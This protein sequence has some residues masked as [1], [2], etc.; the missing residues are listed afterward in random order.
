M[1]TLLI[2]HSTTERDHDFWEGK[3]V[4]KL[5][6]KLGEVH[7]FTG[8][9]YLAIEERGLDIQQVAVAAEDGFGWCSG[10]G[11][12]SRDLDF[13]ITAPK[14]LLVALVSCP[15]FRADF[16]LGVS[17]GEALWEIKGN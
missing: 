15:K 14:D 4:Q 9:L 12:R 7:E 16:L 10:G 3:D 11:R 8:E 6:P 5:L 2:G 17:V 13:V 1:A